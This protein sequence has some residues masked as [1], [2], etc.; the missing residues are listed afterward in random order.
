MGVRFKK[1]HERTVELSFKSLTMIR[2]SAYDSLRVRDCHCG[3]ICQ[4]L[5]PEEDHM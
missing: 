4:G 2:N 1:V 5:I 3:G